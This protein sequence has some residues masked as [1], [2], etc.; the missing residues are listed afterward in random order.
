VLDR[1]SSRESNP[2]RF[3]FADLAIIRMKGASRAQRARTVRL[4]ELA[5][6]SAKARRAQ[7]ANEHAA[8]AATPRQAPGAPDGGMA[9]DVREDDD[10]VGSFDDGGERFA[11]ASV[12]VAGVAL[13]LVPARSSDGRELAR[14]SIVSTDDGDFHGSVL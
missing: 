5:E 11:S 3:G 6:Q 8:P 12:H 1:C 4:V 2:E 13:E 10:H 14:G 7:T 9:I